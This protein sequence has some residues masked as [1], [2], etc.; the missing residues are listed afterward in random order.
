MQMNTQRR[1]IEELE[2]YKFELGYYAPEETKNI[3]WANSKNTV[4]CSIVTKWFKKF[5]SV[6][7]N[8]DVQ[9][10]VDMPKIVGLESLIKAIVANPSSNTGIN[11][12]AKHITIQSFTI[13]ENHPE[14]LNCARRGQ[15]IVKH[16]NSDE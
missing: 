1:L 3:C 6:C 12:R 8:L 9:E 15:N 14:L 11:Y 5:R 4:N 2:I 10:G 16:F 7:K 13:T